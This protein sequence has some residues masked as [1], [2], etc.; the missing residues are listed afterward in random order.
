MKANNNPEDAPLSGLLRAARPSPALP[1]RFQENVWRRIEAGEAGAG[2]AGWLKTLAAL[3][4]QPRFAFAG[5]ALL[6]LAGA[7]LG[8]HEGWQVVR[9]DAQARYLAAVM[10]GSPR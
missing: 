1:P 5:A 7:W 8:A 10:P 4:L 9:Q 6:L 2:S 3:V